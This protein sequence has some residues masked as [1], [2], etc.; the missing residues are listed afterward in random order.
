MWFTTYLRYPRNLLSLIL[1]TTIIEPG[2]SLCERKLPLKSMRMRKLSVLC[3][4][5]N[6][7]E[8]HTT[9]A[10]KSSEPI[11]R[12]CSTISTF[13]LEVHPQKRESSFFSSQ[14][15]KV[16]SIRHSCSHDCMLCFSARRVPKLSRSI[17]DYEK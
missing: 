6:L 16:P 12:C 10:A 8:I 11:K 1:L 15:K 17:E 13:V 2:Y 5:S 3:Q 7:N 4:I 14:T 9:K